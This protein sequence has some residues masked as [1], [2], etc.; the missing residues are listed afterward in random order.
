LYSTV[1]TMY[2]FAKET[3]NQKSRAEEH[4]SINGVPKL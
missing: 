2:A 1:I 4:H 3:Q